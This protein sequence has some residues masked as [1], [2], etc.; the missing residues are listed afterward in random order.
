MLVG[1]GVGMSKLTFSSR[2]RSLAI[3]AVLG[4]IGFGAV[5]GA[6]TTKTKKSTARTAASGTYPGSDRHSNETPLTG[7]TLAKAKAAAEA[8]V[9]GGTAKRATT[10][11]PGDPSGAAYEVHVAKTDGSM[12]KVLEDKDFKVIATQAGHGGHGGR[13]RGDGDH[14][15]GHRGPGG[16]GDDDGPTGPTGPAGTGT[17]E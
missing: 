6:A 7:D 1:D 5:A 17:S 9:S 2:P 13:G 15:H 14:G 4:V 12:V 16:P 3:G 10:E 8:A 11:D